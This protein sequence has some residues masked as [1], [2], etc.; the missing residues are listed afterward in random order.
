MSIEG[1]LLGLPVKHKPI[2][3]NP[4]G[5]NSGLDADKVDGLH[6]A[7]IGGGEAFPVGSVFL[8]VVDTN[9]NTL[10]GYGT[11]SQIAGGRVLIGQT[12]GDAD[13]DVVEEIGGS[14]TVASQ[15]SVSQPTFTGTPS[16]DIVNHTHPITD[17]THS[18]TQ[19]RFPTATGGSTGHTVDTSMSGT[20]ATTAQTTTL[21]AT[22]ISVN[23]P[24]GGVAS[25]MPAGSVS[26]PSFTG[27]ATSVVQPYFVVYIWKRTA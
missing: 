12:D 19:Q 5:A 22:G 13:F 2:D 7:E 21:T 9:P 15:G 6:A 4:Q 3:I 20:L 8:A 24:T 23:N 25:Y 27:S 26:Q 10:L 17:P 1:H 16:S 14:K 11:W 18:H